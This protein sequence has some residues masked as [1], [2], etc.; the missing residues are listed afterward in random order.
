MLH[1]HRRPG[2]AHD[3]HPGPRALRIGERRRRVDRARSDPIPEI[4]K[5]GSVEWNA[6]GIATSTPPAQYLL[7][8]SYLDTPAAH[9]VPES[10][11]AS[12]TSPTGQASS[13]CSTSTTPPTDGQE[14]RPKST[15]TATPTSSTSPPTPPAP[16]PTAPWLTEPDSPLAGWRH[17]N[18]EL[19]N[20][21]HMLAAT[22]CYELATN[23]RRYTSPRALHPQRC[24]AHPRRPLEPYRRRRTTQALLDVTPISPNPIPPVT[25]CSL[26]HD[27]HT[28]RP[29]SN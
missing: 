3:R 28:I 5:I 8:L 4:P 25:N 11:Q 13:P 21:S 6:A 20:G 9:T 23:V 19:D 26:C 24:L 15:K 16:A 29:A 10:W 1:R 14:P 7:R 12:T 22:T 2:V 18:P 27:M 17:H